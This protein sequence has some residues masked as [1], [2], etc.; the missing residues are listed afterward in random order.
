M[1]V[2]VY[3]DHDRELLARELADG[4]LAARWTDTELAEQGV[5]RLDRWP[6]WIAALTFHVCAE[7]PTAPERRRLVTTI[8][9]FLQAL[10]DD[11]A[12]RTLPEIV[13]VTPAAPPEIIRLTRVPPLRASS[14]APEPA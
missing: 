9:R 12:E 8:D 1:I 10:P 7:Y 5:G 13:R 14:V 4:F 6:A 3:T 2:S 11:P